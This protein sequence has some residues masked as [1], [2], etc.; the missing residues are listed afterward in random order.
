MKE[1]SQLKEK[2][3]EEF[4]RHC[5]FNYTGDDER[6]V[7]LSEGFKEAV[8]VFNSVS[9]NSKFFI[10]SITLSRPAIIA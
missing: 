6:K 9:Q 3:S 1:L 7:K 5:L 10:Y 4:K 2:L 8:E